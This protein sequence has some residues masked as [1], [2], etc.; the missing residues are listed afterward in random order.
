MDKSFSGDWL[1]DSLALLSQGKAEQFV[2]QTQ[3][4]NRSAK[5]LKK[6][7]EKLDEIRAELEQKAEEAES[8]S[9]FGKIVAV[10][11]GVVAT[12]V[13]IYNPPAGKVIGLVG[14]AAAQACMV[15]GQ[16]YNDQAADTQARTLKTENFH[17][18]AVQDHGDHLQMLGNMVDHEQ[19]MGQRMLSLIQ[20][21]G[22]SANL[23]NKP[24][25]TR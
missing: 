2:M 20:S 13:G 22:Q 21:E 6:F 18:D 24:G 7:N 10:V 19:A 9:C 23:A 12:V 16:A 3:C 17:R 5:A 4:V 15:T 1:S 8:W 14:L 25:R 11:S